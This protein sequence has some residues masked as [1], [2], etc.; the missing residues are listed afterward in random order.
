M[1]SNLPRKLVP[2]V[3]RTSNLDE[4]LDLLAQ[5]EY[6][7]WFDTR[8]LEALTYA[9]ESPEAIEW[10]EDFKETYCSK[11][12]NE[13]LPCLLVKPINE[14]IRL[15]EKFNKHRSDLTVYDLL[16][17]KYKLAREVL[18]I[19]ERE[20]VLGCVLTGC[21]QLIWLIPQELVYQTNEEET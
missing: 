9:T 13:L 14:Y 4:L 17:H 12:I 3:K 8:L 15:Q 16:K 10:L 20:L 1:G 6:W 7:N 21:V 2:R 19:D 11:K 18:D 5:S